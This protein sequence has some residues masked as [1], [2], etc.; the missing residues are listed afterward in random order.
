MCLKPAVDCVHCTVYTSR[1]LSKKRR[2]TYVHYCRAV[3]T[4]AKNVKYTLLYDRHLAANVEYKRIMHSGDHWIEYGR[5]HTHS[6]THKN[7]KTSAIYA[8]TDRFVLENL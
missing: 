6:M 5:I 2:N 7:S 3:G 4:W 1:Y 8:R